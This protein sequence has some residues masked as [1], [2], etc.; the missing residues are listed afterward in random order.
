MPSPQ[1]HLRTATA[2]DI[3]ALHKLIASSVRGL[4]TSS[5]TEQQLEAALGL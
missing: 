3:P 2:A 4:M 5:Y 1:F